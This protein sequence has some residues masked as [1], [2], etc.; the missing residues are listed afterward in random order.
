MQLRYDTKADALYVRFR[1]PTGRVRAQPL[2]DGL[3]F[4]DRDE[5]G[6]VV[7]VEF[8]EV[9]RGID[10]TDLPEAEAEAEAIAR[11]TE[12]LSR[13]RQTAPPLLV[14]SPR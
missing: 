1:E 11:R 8:I 12:G 13:A 7:G 9:S 2:P 10:L 3:R 4:I 14:G 5:T 6:I